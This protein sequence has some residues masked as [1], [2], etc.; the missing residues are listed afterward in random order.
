[1]YADMSVYM[2]HSRLRRARCIYIRPYSITEVIETP[3]VGSTLSSSRTV[4]CTSVDKF[5][6]CSGSHW[7][8]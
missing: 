7:L 5:N 8:H 3:I 1:M 4:Q 2:G 6:N